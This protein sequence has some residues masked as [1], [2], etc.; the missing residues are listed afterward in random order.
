[1]LTRL[2]PSPSPIRI[3]LID[4]DISFKLPKPEF[5]IYINCLTFSDS[6]FRI[7]SSLSSL[8]LTPFSS[9]WISSARYCRASRTS[10]SLS[11]WLLK[12]FKRASLIVVRRSSFLTTVVFMSY[13]DS[14]LSDTCCVESTEDVASDKCSVSLATDASPMI[15]PTCFESTYFCYS[16]IMDFA[17]PNLGM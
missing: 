2:P 10:S 13:S 5:C 12:S 11:C 9:I 15:G 17:D 14:S 3:Y 4:W 6:L 16:Y 7:E 1:M 8:V